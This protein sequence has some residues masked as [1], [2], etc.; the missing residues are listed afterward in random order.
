[1]GVCTGKP[2]DPKGV[3]SKSIYFILW[4]IIKKKKKKLE[5]K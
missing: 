5:E 1:M 4:R 3:E 2:K